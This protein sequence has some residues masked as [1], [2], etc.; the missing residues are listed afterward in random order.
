M[1]RPRLPRTQDVPTPGDLA[2]DLR[3]MPL[4][5]GGHE[6]EARDDDGGA[7]AEL[8]GLAHSINALAETPLHA[9]TIRE[10]ARRAA[11]ILRLDDVQRA[12]F[13]SMALHGLERM[14]L[15]R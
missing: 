14:T 6:E 1:Q 9:E 2:G 4:L 10:V 7:R 3:F 15:Q 8:A 13:L 5:V 12:H 11:V